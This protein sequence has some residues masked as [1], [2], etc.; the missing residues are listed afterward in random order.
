LSNEEDSI[1]LQLLARFINGIPSLLNEDT[2]QCNDLKQNAKLNKVANEVLSNSNKICELI[3]S[4]TKIVQAH[5][6]DELIL[7][8]N[9][10]YESLPSIERILKLSL[11][12]NDQF[13]KA[14]FDSLKQILELSGQIPALI[15][16]VFEF[17]NLVTLELNLIS[18]QLLSQD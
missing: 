14:N 11:S 5:F 1:V 13:E 7:N 4:N 3:S 2:F 9:P 18:G 15:P 8:L 6:K 10:V 16:A 17:K 12:L